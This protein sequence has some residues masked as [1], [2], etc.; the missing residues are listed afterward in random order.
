MWTA[1]TTSVP[2]KVIYPTPN[3]PTVEGTLKYRQDTNE[4]KKIDRSS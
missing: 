2:A 4:L 3:N 1:Q